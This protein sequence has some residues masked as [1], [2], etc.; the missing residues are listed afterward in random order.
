ML[1]EMH[2]H[3]EELGSILS[4]SEKQQLLEYYLRHAPKEL[5]VLP[6]IE[7]SPRLRLR[8]RLQFD[9]TPRILNVNCV[10]LDQD[11]RTEVLIS[12]AERNA[13]SLL[14][15][16]S[17]GWRETELA[18]GMSAPAR[19]RVVDW[20]SDGDL[21]VVVAGLGH[22]LPT[23]DLVGYVSLLINEGPR[24]FQRLE[25]LT[26]VARVADVAPGDIDQDGDIDLVVGMFGWI[27]TGEIGWLEQRGPGDYQWHNLISMSGSVNV[28]TI[29]LNR[30]GLPDFVALVSQ[31]H[32]QVLAFLN[33]GEG[34][35]SFHTLWAAANPMFGLSGMSV[36]DLDRD[37][38]DDVLFSN[39]DVFDARPELRPHNGIHWLENRGNLDF[40]YRLVGKLYGAFSPVA[41]DLDNDGDLDVVAVSFFNDWKD[42]RR[43]SLVWM[44]NDGQQQFTMRPLSNSP[45]DLP[46]ADLGDFNGDG[47]LD[48]IAGGLTT[49]EITPIFNANPCPSPDDLPCLD[50]V[51]VAPRPSFVLP[52]EPRSIDQSDP[53]FKN[54]PTGE[55]EGE[56]HGLRDLTWSAAE[57]LFYGSDESGL[58]KLTPD[59]QSTFV[60]I[61]DLDDDNGGQPSERAA[62]SGGDR[63]GKGLAFIE[64]NGETRLY[65]G[66]K[67]AKDGL[68]GDTLH[69][70]DPA[71]GEVLNRIVLDAP[72]GSDNA[73]ISGILSM[74]QH[75]ET[76]VVYGIHKGLAAIERELITIDVETGAT[77]LIGLLDE[78]PIASLAFVGSAQQAPVLQPGDSDQD[79]DFDQFDIIKVQQGAKY[80]SGTPATWGEG[81]WDGAPG[82][83]Q[84]D[85]PAGDGLFNQ[86]DII[87]SLNAGFYLAGPY[88]ALSGEQ[89]DR[90]DEQTSLV[91]DANTGEL[92]VD[93]PASTNLTSINIDSAGSLFSGD[94]PEVLDGAFDNFAADNI[95]KATFGGSF[96]DISFGN[97]MPAGLSEADVNADLTAVGSLEGG[98]ELGPVDLIYIP[99]P[100][101]LLLVAL[102]TFFAFV[103]VRRVRRRMAG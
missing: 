81:D 73:F 75:P 46:T 101:T 76:G 22:V 23:D 80:L 98:G 82:G 21:D 92:A 99:E 43:Q 47:R 33:Q 62:G 78:Q 49:K 59:G 18:S 9:E 34:E 44:E 88:A 77:T 26:G 1:T 29:D 31:A 24:G 16:D 100:S 4:E 48:I 38:D 19:T 25:L 84:G 94:K 13:V 85:P 39:G 87:A 3:L 61:P 20:D 69:Q 45:T 40:H 35:F 95:F 71:T 32:E 2:R 57:Q 97:V 67:Q 70:I 53:S 30:D 55:G 58:F 42:R 89:G 27:R 68:T 103:P 83:Q 52:E 37:G 15:P 56:Y 79:L 74:A 6:I 51:P 72:D 54:Y 91:Y 28:A 60:A 36:Q 12:D 14:R 102:A 7:T 64:V 90:N 8:W 17:S 10:D 50:G 41:G 93:A 66:E 96:G 65:L 11:Q 63:H 86:L 5:P